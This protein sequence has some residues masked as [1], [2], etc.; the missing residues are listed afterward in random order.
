MGSKRHS[1]VTLIE[2]MVTIG[3]AAVL[4][5]LA[6]P[7]FTEAILSNRVSTTANVLLSTV[8]FARSEA[9]RS[10]DTA[11]ICPGGVGDACGADWNQGLM[12]WTDENRNGSLDAVEIRRI[13]EPSRGVTVSAS[14]INDEL[15]F[16]NRGRLGAWV[17]AEPVFT[18]RAEVCAAG[19]RHQR[20]IAINAIGRATI[21]RGVCQ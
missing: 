12:V 14:N 18:V 20:S 13:V 17:G 8:N 1:G 16:D 19:A 21:S 7:S 15:V 5:M 10:K 2:L 3:I 4:I 6:L 9:L 11:H